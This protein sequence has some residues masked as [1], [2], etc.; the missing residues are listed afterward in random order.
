MFQHISVKKRSL[1]SKKTI[2]IFHVKLKIYPEFLGK[3]YSTERFS[4]VIEINVSEF[5]LSLDTNMDD[6]KTSFK[7][8]KV[9]G[10]ELLVH[11]NESKLLERQNF[12]THVIVNMKV[13]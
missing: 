7:L 3:Y 8:V 5:I 12:Q 1:F 4:T 13:V 2:E 10:I 6:K 11:K 9:T